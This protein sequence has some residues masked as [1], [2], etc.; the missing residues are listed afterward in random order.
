MKTNV[1]VKPKVLSEWRQH[2]ENWVECDR[3][4]LHKTRR[5]VVLVRGQLPCELLFI[6]GAPGESEDSLGYPFVGSAG[7]EF[8]R[9]MTEALG[10]RKIRYAVTNIIACAPYAES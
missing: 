7:E 1:S 5:N 9:I 4:P 2:W 3:C 8:E 6:G 10:D